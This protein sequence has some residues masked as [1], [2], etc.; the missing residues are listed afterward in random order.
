MGWFDDNFIPAVDGVAYG[1]LLFVVAA[2]LTLAFGSGGVLNLAHGTLY[3]FAAY[4]ATA[5][6]DGSWVGLALAVLAGIGA[7]AA[8]GGVLAALTAPIAG[9]GHMAQAMLTFGVALVGGDLLT[10]WFGKD[11]PQVL[12]PGALEKPVSI[13]GHNYPGYRLAFIVVAIVLGV[14]GWYVLARTRIGA[15][16]RASVDDPEML[17]AGGIS[18]ARVR[19][20]VLVAAGALAGLAGGLGAPIIGPSTSVANTVLL[21]SLLVVVIGGLGSVGGALLAAILVGEVQTL[22]VTLMPDLAPYLLFATMAVMLIARTA[23]FGP[24]GS[25][26]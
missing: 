25:R 23:R 13:L 7:G 5:V 21:Q 3:A 8:G 14:G 17:A 11:D 15:A 24:T 4:T 2:G 1:L 18:P 6:A 12:V 20:G 16:V 9:R 10:T 19:T 26:V 22:G